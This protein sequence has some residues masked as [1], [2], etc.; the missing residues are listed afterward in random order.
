MASSPFLDPWSSKAVAI[1]ESLGLGDRPN[2]SYCYNSAKNSTVLQGVTFG[3][4]PTVLLI[5]VSCFLFLILVFSIIRRRFWDYGRIAL[6]S[7][8][9]SEARFQRSLSSSSGQ[10]DFENELGCCPW[11]TAIFRL[12]DDQILEWC[13]EDAIHYLSFQRHIICLL[14]VISFLSLCVILP[15]NLSGDLLDKDPYSFGRTTIA[16]LQTDNDLLWLHTVFSVIYLFLTV[17]FMWRHTR[18]IRYKEESLVRQT[19]FVTGLPREARKE[20]VES[21]FRDAYPTCEVVDV[22]LCYS[23]AKLMYLCKER[24]KAEKS[25]TYYTNLQAKTGRLTLINPKPCGQFCCCEVQ[26]CEQPA[27]EDCGR[28]APGPG[29]APRDGLCHLP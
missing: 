23:V 3:G 17:G 25:L 19:L 11:L 21:H 2:D 22:Q 7:E 1:R 24:K 26:G 29:P 12:Q 10:Q 13:G 9:G 20:T 14:V 8:T 6:V 15:V 5:D 18:S 16:N 27:G 4:I 28:G